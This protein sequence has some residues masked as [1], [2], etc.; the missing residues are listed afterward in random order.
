MD[1]TR[2]GDY[3][4]DDDKDDDGDNDD[5]DDTYTMKARMVEPWSLACFNDNHDDVGGN[6]LIG[7]LY[8]TYPYPWVWPSVFLFF[9]LL[10]LA[11]SVFSEQELCYRPFFFFYYF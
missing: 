3:D 11:S 1:T 4:Y 7:A 10:C 8:G 5:E 6:S 2:A 9:L